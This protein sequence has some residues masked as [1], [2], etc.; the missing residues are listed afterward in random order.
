MSYQIV[1]RKR[2]ITEQKFD[3]EANNNVIGTEELQ[4]NV[5]A[6]YIDE[7]VRAPVNDWC[8]CLF[9]RGEPCVCVNSL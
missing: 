4:L 2:L 3:H 7:K 1:N 5:S 9:L 8:R 6:I